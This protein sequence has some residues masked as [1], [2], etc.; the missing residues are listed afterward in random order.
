MFKRITFAF[1]LAPL[2][3]TVGVVLT[4]RPPSGSFA[5]GAQ[6]LLVTAAVWYYV[7]GL[8]TVFLAVPLF[9]LLRRLNAVRWWASAGAGLLIGAIGALASNGQTTLFYA[10]LVVLGGLAGLVFWFVAKGDLQ[11]TN[12]RVSGD[13]A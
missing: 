11:S 12:S 10:K 2:V 7:A 13:A 1:L 6:E 3:V 4:T 9:L 5:E 8:F